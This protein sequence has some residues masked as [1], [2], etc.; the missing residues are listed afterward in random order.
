MVKVDFGDC[1]VSATGQDDRS[2]QE[3]G[4]RNH[5]HKEDVGI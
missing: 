2:S 4:R 1:L 3:K 5:V